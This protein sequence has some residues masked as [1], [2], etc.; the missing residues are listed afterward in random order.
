MSRPGSRR[1][2]LGFGLLAA[3][4]ALGSIAIAE[5]YSGGLADRYGGMRPVV[6]VQRDL[7]AGLALDRRSVRASLGVS[8][9]PERFV[10]PDALSHVSEALGERPRQ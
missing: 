9:V 2:A 3:L 5:R 8:E 7:R 4:S 6:V 1:R 10:P